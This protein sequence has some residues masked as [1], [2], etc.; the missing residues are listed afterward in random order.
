MV[1]ERRQNSHVQVNVNDIHQEIT[2]ELN[3]ENN[4]KFNYSFDVRGKA[5]QQAKEWSAPEIFGSRAKF[6]ANSDP[7]T[8]EIEVEIE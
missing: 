7:A 8:L 3:L 6:N 4:P 1:Q 2:G 5:L